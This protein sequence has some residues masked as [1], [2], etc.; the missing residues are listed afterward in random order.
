MTPLAARVRAEETAEVSFHAGLMSLNL[1]K[2]SAAAGGATDSGIAYGARW[3]HSATTHIAFGL[4][5]DFMKPGDKTTDKLIA[6]TQATATTSIDSAALFGVV[7]FGPTEGTVRPNFLL[8]LGLHYTSLQLEAAPKSGFSWP[9]TG[10]AEKRTLIDSG[11]IGMA[12]KIQGG[13][14]YAFT[15]NFLAGLFLAWDSLGGVTY[16]ST[17]QAG[18]LGVNSIRASMSAVSGGAVLTA[19]F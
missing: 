16:A 4:D 3:L 15:D 6:N 12:V 8:G 13:A 2:A 18:S 17:S 11:G 14:D 5:G 7:R 19:R 10:T 1:G 9:D